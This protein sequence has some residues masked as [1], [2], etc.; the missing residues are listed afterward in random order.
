M[1]VHQLSRKVQ[2]DCII[3]FK[4]FRGRL[5]LSSMTDMR[6]SEFRIKC[7]ANLQGI[8]AWPNSPNVAL[9]IDS[10]ERCSKSGAG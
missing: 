9:E 7:I 5:R 10:D 6:I 8:E 2:W 1:K 4:S 3:I